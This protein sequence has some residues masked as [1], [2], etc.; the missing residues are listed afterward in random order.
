MLRQFRSLFRSDSAAVAPMMAMLFP[1]MIGIAGMGVD[2]SH[3][4]MEKRKSQTAT[5][6]AALAAAYEL[7]NN[8]SQSYGTSQGTLIATTNGYT[9]A[10]GGTITFAYS[11]DANGRSLIDVTIKQKANV[12]FSDLFI[13]G[14]VYVTTTARSRVDSTDGPFC[15]LSLDPTT[16]K[17][18]EASGSNT[19][20]AK[21]CGIAANSSNADALHIQGDSVTQVGSVKLAGNYTL[22]GNSTTFDYDSMRTNSTTT[23]DPYAYL[24]AS[25]PPAA[26]SQTCASSNQ[27]NI[28]CNNQC[29]ST[30]AQ[31]SNQTSLNTTTTLQ[32]GT[33]C[34]DIRITGG[35]ITFAPGT[36]YI[37]G[38]SLTASGNATITATGV[39]FILTSTTGS[40]YGNVSITGGVTTL[41]TAPTTGTYAGIAIYQDYRAGATTKKSTLLSID[42]SVSGTAGMTVSG[43]VYTP[44]ANFTFG[45]NG[46]GGSVSSGL[47]SKI[48]AKTIT[49]QGN[50]DI[51]N[52]CN[53]SGTKAIGV[54]EVSLIL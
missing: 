33:Y 20:N 26:T 54:P 48:V 51:D 37:N 35:D 38:G 36:Y 28:T 7:A 16:S 32:P 50:P 21:G 3:W 34:G 13:S 12:W 40:N 6:A 4:M 10:G 17:A 18:I 15:F 31:N 22:T 23:T 30:G 41:I 39:T 43:T 44:S 47:C 42:N 11:T 19:I 25:N 8:L 52:T 46:A 24:Q 5:D 9:S 14:T 1:L 53:T 27:G 45:G 29:N 49:F 2:V